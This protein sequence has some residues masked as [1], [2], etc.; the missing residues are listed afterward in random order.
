MWLA[1]QN[2][3]HLPLQVGF[4]GRD[5]DIDAA[6]AGASGFGFVAFQGGELAFA[7]GEGAVGAQVFFL[8]QVFY[9]A[10]GAQGAVLPVVEAL[11]GDGLVIGMADHGHLH[12]GV[13]Q[14]NGGDLVQQ[15]LAFA[16]DA[17]GAAL[18]KKGGF[19][20]RNDELSAAQAAFPAFAG[21][22]G[23]ERHEFPFQGTE[24]INPRLQQAREAVELALAGGNFIVFLLQLCRQ[25]LLGRRGFGALAVDLLLQDVEPVLELVLGEE[26]GVGGPALKEQGFADGISLQGGFV[27]DGLQRIAGLLAGGEAVEVGSVADA[28][29]QEQQDKAEWK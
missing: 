26:Q 24:P 21:A 16:G 20:D 23:Q 4:Q 19:V 7:G 5:D 2:S 8:G 29:T 18:A 1:F 15:S 13:A 14:G 17:A 6:V 27:Q 9:Y 10:H 28:T 12:F 25:V 3:A 11:A 22:T